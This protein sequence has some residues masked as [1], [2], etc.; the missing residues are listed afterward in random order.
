MNQKSAGA[1]PAPPLRC[2]LYARVSTSDQNTSDRMPST[3]AADGAATCTQVTSP[4]PTHGGSYS[5]KMYLPSGTAD[6]AKVIIPTSGKLS[7]ASGTFF[8]LTPPKANL[9]PL[10]RWNSS[11]TS[12]ITYP[13]RA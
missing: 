7:T 6:F 3:L 12:E 2:A 8:R 4:N 5:A 9:N 13:P 10:G 1:P 11:G